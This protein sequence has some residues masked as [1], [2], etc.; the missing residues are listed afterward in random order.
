MGTTADAGRAAGLEQVAAVKRM[1]AEAAEQAAVAEEHLRETRRKE[2]SLRSAVVQE[3]TAHHA[4]EQRLLALEARSRAS[5]TDAEQPSPDP[6]NTHPDI[7]AHDRIWRAHW[8]LSR[9]IR[10]PSAQRLT[11]TE[12]FAGPESDP[13]IREFPVP[14]LLYAS[15]CLLQNGFAVLDNFWDI[16]KCRR[17]K[18]EI[19]SA[20]KQGELEPGKLGQGPVA[21]GG[22]GKLTTYRSDLIGWR[23][24]GDPGTT[25][26]T[27]YMEERADVFVQK[28]ACLLSSIGACEWEPSIRTKMMFAV[29][30][31]DGTH[32][33]KHYD[34]PNKNGRK[35]TMMLYL[36]E[37]W[38]PE[39]GGL[40]RIGRDAIE[41]AERPYTEIAPLMSRAVVFWS[42]KRCP[43]EVSPSWASRY[44]VTIWYL[45]A[46]E[47]KEAQ[48]RET[49]KPD[50]TAAQSRP[51]E[52]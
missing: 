35:L 27:E 7:A 25:A 17:I 52:L 15:R 44:T 24:G 47:R 31:G 1:F 28:L 29:Y 46:K 40:L 30:P 48:L 49:Q 13:S 5:E 14:E 34:N 43:H 39:H 50:S 21:G 32:Y 8:I 38:K 42:D 36:N 12:R 9:P 37:N 45:D 16:E 2:E 20:W 11:S 33:V 22:D 51:L 26:A 23:E 19:D 41:R 4:L 3:R 18:A 6:C 10:M